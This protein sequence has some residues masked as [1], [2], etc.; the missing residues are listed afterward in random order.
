M[1]N[2]RPSTQAAALRLVAI[3]IAGMRIATLVQMAPSLATA[4]TTDSR[5]AATVATWV[6][7][8][9]ALTVPA[10]LV[11]LRGRPLGPAAAVADVTIAVLLLLAGLWTVPVD[12]RQGTW[13]GFQAGY[14]ICVACSL[15]T[16][17]TSR[18]LY[19]PLLAALAT[20]TAIYQAP[21]VTGWS[22]V[23]DL[24]GNLLTILVLGPLAWTCTRMIIRIG[25]E[26]DEA[27]RL[28]ADAARTEEERRARTAIHN[29]TAVLR[30]LVETGGDADQPAGL[31]QQAEIELSRMRAYLTGDPLPAAGTTSLAAV[32]TASRAEFDDLPIT[33]VAHLA[34]EVELDRAVADDLAAALRSLLLNVRLHAGAREVVLHAEEHEDG[35][36]WEVSLHDD[37]VGFAIDEASYGVGIRDVVV[38]QLARSGVTTAVDSV[39]GLGTT[40]TLTRTEEPA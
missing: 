9:V 12:L 23:P 31:R 8:L 30:L 35:D 16:G 11:V 36:G 1:A 4:I 27:R 20:A 22:D 28:A 2:P 37:G 10:I 14:A 24:L 29:G 19:L 17:A 18:R 32:V 7:A 25:A 38:G 40:I 13:L 3:F 15:L 5:H 6:V 21:T 34:D 26:A 33:V 39:P